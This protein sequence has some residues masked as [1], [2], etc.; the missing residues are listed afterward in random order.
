M[1]KEK[2]AAILLAIKE[3]NE[4]YEKAQSR[5]SVAIQAR[6][7]DELHNDLRKLRRA[8]REG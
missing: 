5:A 7:L 1:L 6:R 3:A 2:E 8:K 4:R